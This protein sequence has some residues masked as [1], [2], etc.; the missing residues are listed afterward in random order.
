LSI[1]VFRRETLTPRIVLAVL[2]VV[3][4]VTFIALFR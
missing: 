2:V 1:F 3:P 4:S